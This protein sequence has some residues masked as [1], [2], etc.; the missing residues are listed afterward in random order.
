VA[1]SEGWTDQKKEE[2][3]ALGEAESGTRSY[4]NAINALGTE[5]QNQAAAAAASVILPLDQQTQAW[6]TLA[7]SVADGTLKQS[8]F[9]STA[10]NLAA[11]LGVSADQITQF[12]QGVAQAVKGIADTIVGTL[13]QAADAFA[14]LDAAASPQDLEQQLAARA[15]AVVNFTANLRTILQSGNADL[16]ALAAQEG[17][18]F[19]QTLADN[20]TKNGPEFAAGFEG[21]VDTAK[22]AGDNLHGFI[23]NELAP[24]IAGQDIP[25]LA[26][27]TSDSLG[28]NLNL[29]GAAV[30]PTNDLAQFFRDSPQID[31]VHGAAAASGYTSGADQAAGMA[32]G[33]DGG[34]GILEQAGRDAVTNVE[35]GARDKAQ[36][37]SPSKLFAKLG[38]DLGD[39]IALGLDQSGDAVVQS[40][41]RIVSDAAKA[42]TATPVDLGVVNK[43]PAAASAPIIQIGTIAVSVTAGPGVTTDQATAVGQAVGAAVVTTVQSRT[44]AQITMRGA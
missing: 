9:A 1:A 6:L 27:R 37:Q 12:E 8:D 43:A 44:N 7:G 13:P 2:V 40:A 21:V 36:S 20:I 24:Q 11:G 41:E 18:Q 14:N 15:F 22:T 39:G 5:Q 32:A 35:N 29:A 42:L 25:S 17:P 38:N 3:L 16:T 26:Q 23:A 4:Q 19:A 34:K 28:L 33:L 30:G 31:D 10:A